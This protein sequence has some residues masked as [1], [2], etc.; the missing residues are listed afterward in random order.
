[1]A[2]RKKPIAPPEPAEVSE[3][4]FIPQ[5]VEFENALAELDGDAG[6]KVSVYREGSGGYRDIILVKSFPLAEFNIEMLQ[7]PPF[8]GGKFR[9][10]LKSANGQMMR[11]I[12]FRCEPSAEALELLKA[13]PVV[14]APALT[15]EAMRA[16][17]RELVREMA[18]ARPQQAGM[19]VQEFIAMMGAMSPL[20]SRNADAPPAQD[21]F[22]ILERIVSIQ[23]KLA[24]PPTNADGEVSSGVVMLEAIKSFGPLI[25]DLAARSKGTPRT[26]QAEPVNAQPAGNPA[27]AALNAPAPNPATEES[28]MGIKM[29]V[30]SAPIL[31]AA[32]HDAEPGTYAN[33][34]LDHFTD[35]EVQKYIGAPDWFEQLTGLVPGLAEYRPWCEKVRAEILAAYDDAA[36]DDTIQGAADSEQPAGNAPP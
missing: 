22:A 30:L 34:L 36:G 32:K 10:H 15:A 17:M 6:G 21:P 18:L 3:D 24:P 13:P 12:A 7:G 19:G 25:Q 2:T 26:V 27:V 31:L 5:D 23:A 4:D 35:E 33:L 20:L 16:E 11:N 9:L 28:E 14:A 8:N 1:M 29:R